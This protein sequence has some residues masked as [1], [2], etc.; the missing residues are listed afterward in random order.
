MKLKGKKNKQEALQLATFSRKIE[1]SEATENDI[2]E[3]AEIFA[4]ELNGGKDLTE[5]AK[6]NNYTVLPLLGIGPLDERLSNLGDQRQIVKWT[7]EKSTELNDIKRF[8]VEKGYAVVKLTKKNKKGLS[9]G[10][11]KL[12][13]KTL[14][15]N[16]KKVAQINEKMEGNSLESIAESFNLKKNT[17]N[18]LSLASPMLSNVGRS[19]DLIEVLNSLETGVLYKSIEAQNG[20]FAVIVKSKELPKEISSF[21]NLSDEISEKMKAKATYLYNTLKKEADITDNRSIFY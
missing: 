14:L 20:V 2:F 4:S 8:D 11:S 19:T 3:K 10:N 1:A 6:E 21:R 5:L 17:S 16:Q 9:I 13:I 18:T 12:R 15:S 7:F